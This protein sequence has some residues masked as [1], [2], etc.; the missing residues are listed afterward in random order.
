MEIKNME[1]HSPYEKSYS[2]IDHII[3]VVITEVVEEE[4][5]HLS[6]QWGEQL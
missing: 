2:L 6:L 3:I 4:A 1:Y 5:E